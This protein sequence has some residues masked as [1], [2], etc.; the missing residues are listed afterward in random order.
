MLFCY[1]EC[2]DRTFPFLAMNKS[3]PCTTLEQLN[4]KEP[5]GLYL[6][7]LADEDS[8]VGDLASDFLQDCRSSK[9]SPSKY[10]TV[11][12]VEL[13]LEWMDACDEALEALQEARGRYFEQSR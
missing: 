9:I 2:T 4:K 12:D 10:K 1:T 6:A 5:F 11:K 3:N 7:G 8:P 13:R